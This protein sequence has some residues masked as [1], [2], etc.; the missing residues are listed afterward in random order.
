MARS[1][2]TRSEALE[3]WKL[4][5]Q[6]QIGFWSTVTPS[7]ALESWK[8][9]RQAWLHFCTCDSYTVWDTWELETQAS[10][11]VT[12]WSFDSYTIWSTRELETQAPGRVTCLAVWQFRKSEY[13]NAQSSNARP[14]YGS[15]PKTTSLEHVFASNMLEH[16]FSNMCSQTHKHHEHVFMVHLRYTYTCVYIHILYI[17]I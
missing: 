10:G 8:L 13:S 5:R 4:K 6:I 16:V 1:T 11:P 9:K 7:E 12:F 2:A 14:V 17:Y 3:S 15:L